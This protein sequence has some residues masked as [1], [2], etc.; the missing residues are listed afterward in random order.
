MKKVLFMVLTMLGFLLIILGY[1]YIETKK[2]NEID[3]Y[4]YSDN[5]VDIVNNK[6]LNDIKINDVLISEITIENN[7]NISLKIR[8]NKTKLDE[9][10]IVFTL[11]NDMAVQAGNNKE[12]NLKNIYNSKKVND[13]YLLKFDIKDIYN[14]PTKVEISL[15]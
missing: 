13:E 14:N 3:I 6:A 5:I 11:Y 10:N 4:K 8:S 12:F 1:N 7:E 9:K 2:N 15:K